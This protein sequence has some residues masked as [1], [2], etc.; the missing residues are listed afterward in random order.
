MTREGS[1]AGDPAEADRAISE[2]VEQAALVDLHAAAP[3]SLRDALGLRLETVDGALVSMARRDPSTLLNR[4]VGVGLEKAATPGGVEKIRM[5]YEESGV[6]RFYLH[7][8]PDARPSELRAWLVEAGWDRARGWMK[9][10][11]EAAAPSE[12]RSDLEIRR[13][14]PEDGLA[15]G[16]IVAQG[17]GLTQTAVPLLAELAGRSSWR[18]YL[19]FDGGT[20]AGA[21]AMF[22][23]ADVAW[24]D[25]AAT[26]PEFRRR[27]SQSAIQGRRIR[28]ALDLGCRAMLTTTGEAVPGDPQHSY[29]N[30]LRAGFQ[31]T[32]LRENFVPPAGGA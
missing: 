16:G 22:L 21:G 14:G 13:I 2:R 31:P 6:R 8:H 7:L 24:F 15:F 30:I 17:F 23:H 26:L 29:H 18:L 20:P 3:P 12:A 11:R 25:W 28:D 5:L 32:D 1:E 9:F 4:V 10:R 19:S 27:G